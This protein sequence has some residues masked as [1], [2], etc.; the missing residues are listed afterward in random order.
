MKGSTGTAVNSL[1]SLCKFTVMEEI[2][3]NRTK[4]A[5]N[6]ASTDSNNTAT[7]QPIIFELPKLL[8]D[9]LCPNDCSGNGDC[10]NSKCI[11]YGNYTSVDC[12]IEKGNI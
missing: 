10:V 1:T 9:N 11:C 12:S 2:E 5:N 4:N 3:N 8:L 6:N 7:K